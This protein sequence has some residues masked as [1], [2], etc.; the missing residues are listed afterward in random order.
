MV[1]NNL[2]LCYNM[3]LILAFIL[4]VLMCL[5]ML[6]GVMYYCIDLFKN[7]SKNKNGNN[8]NTLC[9]I[10]NF[11]NKNN[12]K[13]NH[14]NNN[15][16]NNNNNND[17]KLVINMIILLISNN[18]ALLKVIN[19]VW[20]ILCL[21]V[22]K[23]IHWLLLII[24]ILN[25]SNVFFHF[26]IIIAMKTI[27]ITNNMIVKCNQNDSNDTR[28]SNGIFVIIFYDILDNLWNQFFIQQCLW[29]LLFIINVFENLVYC[30]WL[31]YLN[32]SLN[33]KQI[34]FLGTIR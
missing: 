24:F 10:G 34:P 28:N 30:E 14:K 27:I 18:V 19:D 8:S 16:N 2:E 15:N 26:A 32:F 3:L 22:K 29:L 5:L 17:C 21:H 11:N 7:I 33:W 9:R 12:N 4:N 25:F 1:C 31:L 6:N 23:R 20:L 13:N